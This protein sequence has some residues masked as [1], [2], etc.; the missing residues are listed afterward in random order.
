MLNHS[1]SGPNGRNGV[2]YTADVVAAGFAAV[3][4]AVA[5]VVDDGT[6]AVWVAEGTAVAIA[7]GVVCGVDCGFGSGV[8]LTDGVGAAVGVG[9]EPE[10]VVAAV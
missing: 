2:G 4:A 1:K 9:L 8:E 7:C 6:A 3:V 5:P 10:L